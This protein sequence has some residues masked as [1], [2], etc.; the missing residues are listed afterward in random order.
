MT[1]HLVLIFAYHFPPENA[2]GGARPF[3]FAKYL[4][5]MG[6]TCRV[7][8]A[9]AQTTGDASNAVYIPDPFVVRPRATIPWQFERVIRKLI[10]PGELGTL[11]SYHAYRAARAYLRAHHSSHVT[12]LST[13]PPLGTHL[14]AWQLARGKGFRWIA[15]FR[16]PPTSQWADISPNHPRRRVYRW[17]ERGLM[18][19]VDAVIANTDAA[20]AQWQEMYPSLD[21]KV[22]LIW[23][24]FDPEDRIQPL[25]LPARGYKLLSHV[26]ELYYGRT[27]TQILES[28]ARLIAAGRLQPESVRVRLV[29]RVEPESLPDPEFVRQAKS[30]GWLELVTD[31]IPQHEARQIAQTSDGL[32]LLQP[33]SGVQVPGKLFEYLQI[34]RPILAFI[35]PNSPAQR[36]LERA[37]VPY[38]CVYPGDPPEKVDNVVSDFFDIPSTAVASSPWFQAQFNAQH[39]AQT[40]D[41]LIRSLHNRQSQSV[42]TS[43][44]NADFNVRCLNTRTEVSA[45]LGRQVKVGTESGVQ[46]TS[47]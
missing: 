46:T 26:G 20:L 1:E 22:H 19:K 28:F 38:R 3:R 43:I 41:V 45:G 44:K 34:G 23:N 36:L 10:L 32:L 21:N 27:A 14:A 35:Q 30:R 16:D 4:S 2:I 5:R 11:W 42:P 37:G 47:P 40:L 12:I 6:Y 33:Q 29:G 24:G 15:D 7:F 39:Q 9:A 13:F 18:R 31:Q 17:V 8:T 25:P